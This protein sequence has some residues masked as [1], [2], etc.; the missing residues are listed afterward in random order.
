MPSRRGSALRLEATQPLD[1]RHVGAVRPK[2][3]KAFTIVPGLIHGSSAAS[4]A[5]FVACG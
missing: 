4:A 5:S 3:L 1:R 2:H